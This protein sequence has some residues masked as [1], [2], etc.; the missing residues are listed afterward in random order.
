VISG[1]ASAIPELHVALD[2]ALLAGETERAEALDRRLQ[3]FVAWIPQFPAPV[4]IREAA[5]MRGIR[6]GP[7]AAPP[8]PEAK[9]RLAHFAE[10]FKAWLPEMLRECSHTL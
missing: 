3:E 8:G 2:R 7:P 5:A 9:Q 4:A 6:P 10:W 1:I